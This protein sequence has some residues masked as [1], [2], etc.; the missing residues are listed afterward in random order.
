MTQ[1]PNPTLAKEGFYQFILFTI[2]MGASIGSLPELYAN[3]QK[4]LGA[5]RAGLTLYL[6]PLYVA[7][8][9]FLVLGEPV[10]FYHLVGAVVILPGIYLASRTKQ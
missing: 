6:S 8:T 9:A 1:G 3:L 7:V 5:A 4:A 10:Y 2:M